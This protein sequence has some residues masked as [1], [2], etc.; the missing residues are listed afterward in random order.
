[1]VPVGEAVDLVA[2]TSRAADLF[3]QQ[4]GQDQ[5][6]LLTAVLKETSWKGGELRMSLREPFEDLRLSNRE[7]TRNSNNS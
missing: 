7:T 2:L 6:K 4:T 1:M 3:S 5:R